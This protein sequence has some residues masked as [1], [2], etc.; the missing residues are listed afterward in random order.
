MTSKF[1]LFNLSMIYES[2]QTPLKSMEKNQST[3]I[4]D[5][6]QFVYFKV[7]PVSVNKLIQDCA[8]PA[9]QEKSTIVFKKVLLVLNFFKIDFLFLRALNKRKTILKH[10]KAISNDDADDYVIMRRHQA[11]YQGRNHGRKRRSR[12]YL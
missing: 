7:N 10:L 3:I 9:L 1:Q 11:P 6:K 8:P 2:L 5:L 12:D 4:E